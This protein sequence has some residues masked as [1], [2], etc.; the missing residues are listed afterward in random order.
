M[1]RRFFCDLTISLDPFVGCTVI[2]SV[3]R[4]IFVIV[5][6]VGCLRAMF[7]FLILTESPIANS[8]GWSAVAGPVLA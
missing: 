3:A 1:K 4:L 5:P 6:L 8:L 2:L 7:G